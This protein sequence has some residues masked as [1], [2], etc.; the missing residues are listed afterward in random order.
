M[1]DELKAALAALISAAIVTQKVCYRLRAYLTTSR[2]MH[3]RELVGLLRTISD[4]PTGARN[5]TLVAEA[6]K[7]LRRA[8]SATGSPRISPLC[9]RVRTQ[10]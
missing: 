2:T 4:L 5:S 3:Q 9:N 7:F 6:L 10:A 1:N 8:S